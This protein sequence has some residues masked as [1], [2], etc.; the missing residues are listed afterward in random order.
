MA[1]TPPSNIVQLIQALRTMGDG[2]IAFVAGGGVWTGTR[3][4]VV[5]CAGRRARSGETT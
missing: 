3:R 2:I 1:N 4:R 5:S